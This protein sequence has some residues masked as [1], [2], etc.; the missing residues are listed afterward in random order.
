MRKKPTLLQEI[1]YLY[2][3][4]SIARRPR[5][6]CLGPSFKSLEQG[7]PPQTAALCLE[8][9]SELPSGNFPD[10][11]LDNAEPLSINDDRGILI[12][13]GFI[14]Y[15]EE[16]HSLP[17]SYFILDFVD[18]L[19]SLLSTDSPLPWFRASHQPLKIERSLYEG[20]FDPAP[21]NLGFPFFLRL[22]VVRLKAVI[23]VVN[24][25]VCLGLTSDRKG[26][27]RRR[28]PFLA[29]PPRIWGVIYLIYGAMATLLGVGPRLLP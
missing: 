14:C 8:G 12:K 18:S 22:T 2:A 7:L 24:T 16:N 21:Q 13:T 29:S 1:E 4:F 25:V 20:V 10:A 23:G 9:A 5:C 3:A 28:D 15:C 11:F 19:Q 6:H 27:L 17:V 26:N